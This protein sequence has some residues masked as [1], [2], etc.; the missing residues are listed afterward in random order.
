LNKKAVEGILTKD[1]SDEFFRLLNRNEFLSECI[2]E[3]IDYK[4]ISL[5]KPSH[6]SELTNQG[7]ALKRAY[8]DGGRYNLESIKKL[9]MGE[10]RK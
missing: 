1:R 5:S 4:L 2:I 9:F 10:Q 7:W 8:Q 6:A 3:I